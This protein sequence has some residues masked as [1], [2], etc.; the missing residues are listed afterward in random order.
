MP[1]S[2]PVAINNKFLQFLW[3]KTT[4]MYSQKFKIKVSVWPPSL[5]GPR[6]ASPLPLPSSESSSCFWLVAASS[7]LCPYVHTAPPLC[8]LLLCLLEGQL[9]LDLGSTW[10]VQDEFISGYLITSAK[11]FCKKLIFQIIHRFWGCRQTYL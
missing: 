3:P 8:L 4:Q 1:Y 9:S 5:Q 10:T 11:S 6:E 7:D 2:F